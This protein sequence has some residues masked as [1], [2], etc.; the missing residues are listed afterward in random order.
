MNHLHLEE[1]T[2]KVQKVM[3]QNP[4][5][6]KSDPWIQLQ[7]TTSLPGPYLL[8]IAVASVLLLVILV[9]GTSLLCDLAVLGLPAA[10]TAGAITKA[11]PARRQ[12]AQRWLTYWT[13]ATGARFA[14]RYLLGFLTSRIPFFFL[15]KTFFFIWC[16]HPQTQG[17]SAVYEELLRPHLLPL[18]GIKAHK[19]SMPPP[20]GGAKAAGAKGKAGAGAKGKAAGAATPLPSIGDLEV[21]VGAA[22]DLTVMDVF[23][24]ASDPY[25]V[26]R[27]R[28]PQGRPARGVEKVNFKTACKHHTTAPV[29]NEMVKMDGCVSKD[30]T[31]L[32]TV[33]NKQAVG[34]DDFI[35]SVAVPLEA[36]LDLAAAAAA[37]AAAAEGED[38][39]GEGVDTNANATWYTLADP[40]GVN[41]KG[42]Q[43]ELRLAFAFRP[44]N[45]SAAAAASSS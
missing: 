18:L 39:E 36:A 27:L 41:T 45:S 5:I 22:R 6:F 8:V 12:G 21:T 23:S 10:L 19:H 3:D 1:L 30:S 15:I 25:C 37:P 31:L 4:R 2:Q 13:V 11:G 44:S 42:A 35:G 14:D 43:G 29:W 34:L 7:T 20:P 40:D 26:L 38:G 28:P 24:G 16:Y 17:A 9:G 33:M 32:V